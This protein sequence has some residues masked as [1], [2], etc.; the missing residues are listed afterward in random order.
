[1]TESREHSW[2]FYLTTHEV[3]EAMYRDCE[4]AKISIE[5]EQYIFGNDSLGRK[6]M[7]LFIRK[8]KEGI[9]IF[10][11]CDKFGS[12]KLFRSPLVR[13]LRL[14]G[15]KFYFYHPISAWNI[16]TPWWWFPRTHTK[17]LLVDSSIA[18]VGSACMEECMNNWRD[19]QV[20]ITGPV[21]GYVR[22]AF[23]KLEYALIHRKKTAFTEASPKDDTFRYV[24]NQPKLLRHRMYHELKDSIQN[25]EHY[26]YIAVPYFIPNNRF[27][28]LLRHARVRG[29]EVTLLITRHSDVPLA[30]WIFLSYSKRLLNA[31]VDVLRY[32]KETLHCKTAVIDDKWATVGSTNFDVLSFFHNRE[33]NIITTDAK[34]VS[35]IKQQFLDDLKYGKKLTEDD[36]YKLPLHKRIASYLARSL[37]VFF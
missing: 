19:T 22:K 3:W 14:N 6:F 4:E 12:M 24:I 11:I 1:M 27:F 31:G 15:G 5:L 32:C 37:K 29:V 20:R 25:A 23:D 9:K 28:K 16:L 8:A 10:I 26:I 33:A 7:E 30:D 17:A 18:Y 13:R 35:E 34:A 36:W 21:V 2:N